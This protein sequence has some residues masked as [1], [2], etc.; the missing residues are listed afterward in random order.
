MGELATGPEIGILESFHLNDYDHVEKAIRYLKQLG[1]KELRT[2][3]SWADYT[4]PAGQKWYDWLLPRLSENFSVLPCFLYTP[5]SLGIVSS[6]ISPPK[7]PLDYA[8]FIALFL[9][10]HGKHFEYIML[11]NEPNNRNEYDYTLDESWK[12]F[13][14]MIILASEEVKKAGMKTVLGGISPIDP[15]FIKRMGENKVLGHIDVIGINGFPDVFDSNW[16]SWDES[17]DSIQ[18]ALNLYNSN[19]EIWITETG[20]STWRYD[21]KIQVR[22]FIKVLGTPVRRVY[23]NSLTDVPFNRPVVEGHYMDEREYHFGMIHEEGSQ[24]LLYRLWAAGGIK[25]VI[26]NQWMTSNE[27]APPEGNE[28]SVLITGGAGFIGTNLANRLLNL[29]HKVYIFDNL[30]RLGVENNLKWLRQQHKKNLNII[31][32][33]VRD[34]FAVEEAVQKVSHVFHLAGQVAVT[35]SL[36]NPAHDYSVNVNGTLNLLEAI[37]KSEHKP[38]L[39]FT[40]TNKVYGNLS[41]VSIIR[42]T[43]RYYPAD[44][45]INKNGLNELIRLDFQSPYGSSKGSA[46]Q[47]ILDYARSF[48]LRNVVFR[49]SCIYGEHQFGTEDQGWVAHFILKALRNEK[50]VLYGD[51]MQVRDILYAEDLVEAF[52]L[53]WKNIDTFSGEAFNM[54]G[55]PQN[56]ISLLEL[57]N[58]LENLLGRPV[59]FSFDEWRKGDQKYYISDTSKF[60]N[61]TG[62]KPRI[63][64]REGIAILFEWLNNFYRFNVLQRPAIEEL[65]IKNL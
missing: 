46:D 11:W 51:G 28:V 10:R 25:N 38:S 2:D 13:S 41:D 31:I 5:H 42:N 64:A 35:T 63:S 9:E 59:L 44:H 16:R 50:I 62:W 29:G 56:S 52:L 26:R 34:K 32:S 22:K 23:W 55:G 1:I 47:Y 3:I 45:N 24:K 58:L 6:I 12:I 49:M 53:A 14:R 8:S 37:R 17:I 20:Y 15:G 65:Q 33:D 54:G 57:I 39:I 4:R 60:S 27:P 61:A 30:S 19:A 40:S 18:N 43:T 7:E 21:E 36:L 48:G